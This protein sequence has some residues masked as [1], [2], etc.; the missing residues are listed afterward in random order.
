MLAAAAMSTA[1]KSRAELKSLFIRL[2]LIFAREEE[3][4]PHLY[5]G[6]VENHFRKTTLSTLNLDLPVI[7]SLLCRV[8]RHLSLGPRAVCPFP[9]PL[10]AMRGWLRMASSLL[11]RQ[12]REWAEL[13]G[14]SDTITRGIGDGVPFCI[15]LRNRTD[16]GGTHNQSPD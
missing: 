16:Q 5:G 1:V 8:F 10:S 14:D 2:R 12:F 13:I 7:G 11:A 15:L 9:L 3:V 6:R 4:Y